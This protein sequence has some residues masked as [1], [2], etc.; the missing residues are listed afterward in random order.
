MK[1]NAH[2]VY[3]QLISQL[4]AVG[5]QDSKHVVSELVRSIF[6]IDKMLYFVAP[7]WWIP[8]LQHLHGS[9][10]QLLVSQPGIGKLKPPIPPEKIVNWEDHK[11][12]SVIII[13]SPKVQPGQ[14]RQ[15]IGMAITIRWR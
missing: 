1:R 7:E 9:Q 8:R 10:Q 6:D 13:I 12:Q 15:F 14:T 4:M 3:R 5:A 2:T 11:N